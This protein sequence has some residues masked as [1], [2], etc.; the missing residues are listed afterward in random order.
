MMFFQPTPR[1]PH[2]TQ[3][4]LGQLLEASIQAFAPPLLPVYQEIE[5]L[6][7]S[8]NLTVQQRQGL[9]LG[10]GLIVGCVAYRVIQALLN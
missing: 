4:S 3:S 6:E 10:E 7:E 9:E 8:P 2:Q 5:R 1:Y